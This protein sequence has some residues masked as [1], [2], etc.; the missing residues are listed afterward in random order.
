[1]SL[2]NEN[3]CLVIYEAQRSVVGAKVRKPKNMRQNKGQLIEVGTKTEIPIQNG[4]ST[5]HLILEYKVL[6]RNTT[7]KLNH[8]N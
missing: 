2:A 6:Y 3:A 4:G 5:S 1:M 8:F 7:L